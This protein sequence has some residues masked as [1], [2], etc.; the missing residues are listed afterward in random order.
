MLTISMAIFNSILMH[1]VCLPEGISIS[2]SIYRYIYISIW[3]GFLSH[4]GTPSHH[5]FLLAIFH[6]SSTFHRVFLWFSHGFPMVFP[7]GFPMVLGWFS[8]GFPMVF[9]WFS[10]GFRMVFLWFSYGFPMV[11]GWFS[12]GFPMVF[13]W[14]SDGFPMVFLWF[15]RPPFKRLNRSP[16]GEHQ[17]YAV[18]NGAGLVAGS[19]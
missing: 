9:P 5:P 6:D 4:R 2:I 12:Y 19:A 10:H 1:F 14:F 18:K 8:Y 17:S 7:Y 13:P 16:S 11:F 3:G 15:S